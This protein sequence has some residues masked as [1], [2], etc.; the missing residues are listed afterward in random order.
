MGTHHHH[1]GGHARVDGGE[2]RLLFSIV[3]NLFIAVVQFAGGL[4]SGSLALLSDALHNATDASS[5]GVSYG[6][7]R[8]S[9]RKATSNKTFGYR[10]AEIIGAFINLI[11]LT[12]IGFYLIIEAV[13]RFFDPRAID[14]TVM[15]AIALASV[16]VNVLTGA[17][18][19]RDAQESLNVRSAFLH[20][21]TDAVSSAAI[22]LGGLL[23]LWLGALWIDPLLT[24]LIALYILYHSY[25]LLRETVDILMESVPADVDVEEVRA[26]IQKEAPVQEVHH[27]HV[28]RLDDRHTALEAHV[29]IDEDDLMAMEAIKG[30][31]KARLSSSFGIEHSTLEFEVAPCQHP[32]AGRCYVQTAG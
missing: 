12:L 31:I 25:G 9:R 18:L 6:A 2:K 16:A 30:A 3:L 23:I 20:I 5:L 29:V 13:E 19:Y 8:I 11:V 7:R 14:S 4:L 28:W 1:H 24:A 17:I 10:R 22:V 15:I 21:L 27:L 26:A 32:Q